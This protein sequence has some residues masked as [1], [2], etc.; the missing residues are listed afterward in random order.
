M[1]ERAAQAEMEG[2]RIRKGKGLRKRYRWKREGNRGIERD[3]VLKRGIDEDK[4]LG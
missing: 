3:I 1:N 4:K 2:D